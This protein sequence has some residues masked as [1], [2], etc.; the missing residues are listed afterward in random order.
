MS[1]EA[2]LTVPARYNGPRDSGQGGYTAGLIAMRMGELAEVTLRSPI[3]LDR[4]LEIEEL[5]GEGLRLLD[6][7]TLV[8][9]ARP[10]EIDIEVPAPVGIEDARLATER[11]RGSAGTPFGRCFV[12]GPGREDALG[13][14]AGAVEGRDVVASPWTPGP[15]TDVD[16]SGR[17]APEFVW[18]VLDCPTYFAL[19]PDTLPISFLA[20]F[21]ARVDDLPELGS[22]HVVMAW[23]ISKDGRKHLA[24]SALLDG[25]GNVLAMAEALLIEAKEG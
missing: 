12:C 10:R 14:M 22:E 23:P 18:A 7:E 6:G 5:D 2:T 11:Y 16:G 25:D 20:R 9:E 15:E 1:A 21:A 8:A 4:E 17:A 3:P 19:Y 13:V 24:G